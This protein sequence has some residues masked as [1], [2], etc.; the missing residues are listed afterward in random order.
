ML[1]ISFYKL[2]LSVFKLLL[3]NIVLFSYL[4]KMRLIVNFVIILLC[5][6]YINAYKKYY[7]CITYKKKNVIN[8]SSYHGHDQTYLFVDVLLMLYFY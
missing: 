4:K 1:R 8:D 2:K 6:F 3:L 7:L 5:S